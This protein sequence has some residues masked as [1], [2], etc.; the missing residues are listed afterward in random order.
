[1]ASVNELPPL[2]STL[3]DQLN[4]MRGGFNET[5]GLRFVSAS[6][7]EVVAEVEIT[8]AL[9]QPYGLVH[10]GVYSA[11]IETLTSVGAALNLAAF[12]RHCVGLE[13]HSSFL[14]AVREGT[15]VGRA[16]PLSRGR[17][18]QV[19]EATITCGDQVVA[20]GRVRLMGIERDRAVAGERISS[21]HMDNEP[22]E[23]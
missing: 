1:M 9:H 14:E 18:S 23:A 7:E 11:M 5:L 22:P 17:R 6:Y 15:L 21:P 20:T 13:N 12:D 19:W 8:P 2:P 3:V 16:V 4:H 10:G